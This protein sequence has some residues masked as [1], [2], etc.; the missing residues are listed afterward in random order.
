MTVNI[1][2]YF[3][4]IKKTNEIS[5]DTRIEMAAEEVEQPDWLPDVSFLI[6]TFCRL[7]LFFPNN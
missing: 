7:N 6:L 2:I 3:N 1:E 5:I 4:H